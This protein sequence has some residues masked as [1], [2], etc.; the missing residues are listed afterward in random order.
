MSSSFLRPSFVEIG[1]SRR[2]LTLKYKRI[3]RGTVRNELEGVS[4]MAEMAEDESIARRVGILGSVRNERETWIDR[5]RGL[6]A[7]RCPVAALPLQI[8]RAS[9]T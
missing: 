9:T 5:F 4:E 3:P 2:S 7:S 6:T 8:L 1:A